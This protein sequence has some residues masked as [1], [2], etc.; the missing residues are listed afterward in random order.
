M[1]VVVWTWREKK[2]IEILVQFS[3]TELGRYIRNVKAAVCCFIAMLFNIYIY[4][5]KT[6]A[7]EHCQPQGACLT[8]PSDLLRCDCC[9][10]GTQ[11]FSTRIE[12]FPSRQKRAK[13]AISTSVLLL[14]S[15]TS[16]FSKMIPVFRIW[17]KKKEE[18]SPSAIT[19]VIICIELVFS[20][21]VLP[22]ESFT[23]D[24]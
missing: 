12:H 7:H 16:L 8:G 21:Y 13:C 5:Y 14:T 2:N 11:V 22:T 9:T 20:K 23:F 24:N 4:I 18:L 10:S 1:D 17:N 15:S 6:Q 3:E 19:T